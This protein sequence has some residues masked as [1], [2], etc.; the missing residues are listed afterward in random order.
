MIVDISNLL[1]D[2]LA[3]VRHYHILGN[4]DRPTTADEP[5]TRVTERSCQSHSP[6]PTSRLLSHRTRPR[7]HRRSQVATDHKQ[8]LAAAQ[9][10]HSAA[11]SQPASQPASQEASKQ[12]PASCP[13][14]T[15]THVIYY[16]YSQEPIQP[17][18]CVAEGSQLSRHCR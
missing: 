14:H 18:V 12:Q 6:E 17:S 9:T 5:N 15:Y 4:E 13:S 2:P 1:N 3:V 11:S 10:S 7:K 8:A 16:F